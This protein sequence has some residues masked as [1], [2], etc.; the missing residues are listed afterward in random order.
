MQIPAKLIADVCQFF[1]LILPLLTYKWASIWF[2]HTTR[3]LKISLDIQ[4][5]VCFF[6]FFLIQPSLTIPPVLL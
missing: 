6:V 2:N 1:T 5:F 4:Y 3:L